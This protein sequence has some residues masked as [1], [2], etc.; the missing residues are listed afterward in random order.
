MVNKTARPAVDGAAEWLCHLHVPV[1]DPFLLALRVPKP[2]NHPNVV[3]EFGQTFGRKLRFLLQVGVVSASTNHIL[4][5][6]VKTPPYDVVQKWTS[7]VDEQ[8]CSK[9]RISD[10]I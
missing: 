2:P 5:L 1:L 10:L 9:E 7:E 6:V 3:D 8:H 4:V